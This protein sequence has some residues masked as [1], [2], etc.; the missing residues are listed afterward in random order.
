[1]NKAK[2]WSEFRPATTIEIEMAFALGRI[3]GSLTPNRQRFVT[4][5]AANYR[6]AG[7][8]GDK[9]VI[10]DKQA[11]FLA[12]CVWRYR[13]RLPADLVLAAAIKGGVDCQPV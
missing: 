1:M 6:F 11:S 8:F 7:R 10:T 13:K 3:V 2:H 4:Q 12:R 9:R 5:L